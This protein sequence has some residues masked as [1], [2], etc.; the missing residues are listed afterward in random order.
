VNTTENKPNEDRLKSIDIT[1]IPITTGTFKWPL[2]VTI[3]NILLHT[4]SLLMPLVF[5][6]TFFGFAMWGNFFHWRILLIFVDVLVVFWGAYLF[7]SLLFGKLV[8]VL[9]NLIHKPKEGLF[10]AE[11][12]DRDYYFFCLRVAVKRHIFWIWNN[13][14]FPWITNVAFK[15][16]DMSADFKSTLF[17]G[18]SDV[19]FI[20]FGNNMMLGQG[21]VVHSSIIIKIDNED[22]LLVK[23]VII[24]D[25]VVLGGNSHVA[26]G[27]IIGKNSTLGIWCVTHINQVLEPG[28]IY[29]GKPAQKYKPAHI[30]REESKKQ[31]IRRIVDTNERIPYGSK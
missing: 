7:I 3:I 5:I 11:K 14:C 16:C 9:L 12:K 25:H 19:E 27:T 31:P 28:W 22:Y 17:D 2:M 4:L 6:L 20:E 24:G 10:K 1:K 8:L 30:M 29:I 26:P 15:L 21:A 23:K 13:F 18:W